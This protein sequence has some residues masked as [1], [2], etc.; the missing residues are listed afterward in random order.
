MNQTVAN[1]NSSF[2]NSMHSL[3]SSA[4]IKPGTG[5]Q[6]HPNIADNG[7]KVVIKLAVVDFSFSSSDQQCGESTGSVSEKSIDD[8]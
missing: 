2:M 7:A 1:G 4:T 3:V 5:N 6:A 8:I